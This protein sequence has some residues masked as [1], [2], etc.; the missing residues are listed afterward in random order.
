VFLFGTRLTHVT[1]HLRGQDVDVALARVAAAAPDWSGGTRIGACLY[2]F[3]LRWARRVL[4][5]GAQVLL[6]TDGLDR[7]DTTLLT[8]AADRLGRSCRN[9]IWL[10]PLLRYDGFEP[11]AAGVRALLPHVDTFVPVHNLNSI[12]DLAQSLG[13]GKARVASTHTR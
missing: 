6:L 13:G 8:K 2:E 1:R 4:G 10:N 9:L 5:Y 11:R 3:N 12:A 7:E